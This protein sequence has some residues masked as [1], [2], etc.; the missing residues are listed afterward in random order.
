MAKSQKRRD[1]PEGATTVATNRVAHRDYEIV[2]TVEVGIVLR[3]SEVKSLRESKVQLG[4]AYGI[5]YQRELWLV[6]LRIGAYSHSGSA[7][8]HDPERRRK[9]LAH[10]DEIERWS[11]RVD[12]D[13]L[14]VI[15]LALY[16]VGGRAKLKLALARGKSRADR[17]QEI[18]KRD[19]NLETQKAIAKARRS[20]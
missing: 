2:D 4:E 3:G 10:R 12:R 9:L 1:V 7:F 18:A 17:R 20:G 11:S 14:A 19:S 15:P 6:G 13:H 8:A 16:F 5:F